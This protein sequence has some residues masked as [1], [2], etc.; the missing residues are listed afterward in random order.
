M[1][2][3][4]EDGVGVG[5]GRGNTLSRDLVFGRMEVGEVGTAVR[6]IAQGERTDAGGG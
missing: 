2:W 4:L 6:F 3:A 1:F 5:G